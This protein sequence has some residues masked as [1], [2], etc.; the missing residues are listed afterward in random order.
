MQLELPILVFN[1]NVTQ[2]V[3]L[4]TVPSHF[5]HPFMKYS[6]LLLPF[7]R[8]N[9]FWQILKRFKLNS[10]SKKLLKLSMHMVCL[11]NYLPPSCIQ[12]FY[13]KLKR[14]FRFL[15]LS[16]KIAIHR[17]TCKWDYQNLSLLAFS[18]KIPMK[19]TMNHELFIRGLRFIPRF[20]HLLSAT[21]SN[22]NPPVRLMFSYI[23]KCMLNQMK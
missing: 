20:I 18:I 23:A 22:N 5:V 6:I 1:V 3:R 7:I 2:R 13:R 4:L 19:W 10:D 11:K 21:A 12:R 14:R 9:F 8:G 15:S 17:T 16:W